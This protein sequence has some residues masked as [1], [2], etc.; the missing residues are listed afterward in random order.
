[1]ADLF[2]ALMA[3][4]LVVGCRGGQPREAQPPAAAVRLTLL[5]E[6]VRAEPRADVMRLRVRAPAGHGYEPGRLVAL[7]ARVDALGEPV[8]V[9]VA[10]IVEVFAH[11]FELLAL[12][13]DPARRGQVLEVGPIPSGHHF[14]FRLGQILA[15]DRDPRRAR[16]NMGD[17][18]GATVGAM[19]TVL[20]DPYADIDVGGRSL[21]RASVGVVQVVE[22]DPGGHTALVELRQGS[23]PVGAYVRH[24][25]HEPVA[26]RPQIRILVARFHGDRGDVYRE[27][28]IQ[29][30]ERAVRGSPRSEVSVDRSEQS[31]DP[32]DA[33][34]AEATRLGRDHRADL[35]VWGSASALGDDLIVRPRLTL[36][37]VR[38]EGPRLWDPLVVAAARLARAEPDALSRRLHGLAAYLV[39]RAY[40]TD[41]EAK[42]EGSYARAASHF[43][44]AIELGDAVEGERAELALFE[45]LDRIG[46]WAGA[47]RLA[48]AI[49][50]SGR[51]RG[52]AARRAA[53]LLLRARV[54]SRTGELGAALADARAAAEAFDVLGAARER[55]LALRHVADILLVKGQV[56]ASLRLLREELLPV[57]ERLGD[58]RERAVTLGKIADILHLRGELDEAL[59]IRREEVL[60]V[61]TAVGDPR[62]R[63]LTQRDIS[64]ALFIR[65]ELDEALR[66]RQREVLPVLER[67]GDRREQA[68]TLGRIADVLQ[69]RGDL[70]AAL[71]VWRDQALPVLTALG[72][73]AGQAHT[74]SRMA[75]VHQARGE[76][77][78]A[79][80][81]RRD[82]VLPRY[83]KLGDPRG[84]AITLGKLAL[85]T[86]HRG[87]LDEALRVL[88]QEQLPVHE[89]LGDVLQRAHTLSE[90]AYTR[91]L[92]GEVDVA[93]R[94]YREEVLPAYDRLGA[95][96]FRAG[97]TSRIASILRDHGEADEALRLYLEEVLPVYERLG[98]QRH[99]AAALRQVAEVRRARGERGEALRLLRDAVE[100]ARDDPPGR[101]HLIAQMV[102]IRRE[103]GELDEALRLLRDELLPLRRAIGNKWMHALTLDELA[104]LVA[105]RGELDEAIRV[106]TRELL[107]M[108][109]AMD[110][111][112]TLARCRWRTA[113]VLL[114]RG[115]TGDREAAAALLVQAQAT[116]DA[117]ALPFARDIAAMRAQHRL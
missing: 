81:I 47:D 14:G 30:L 104:E 102:E 22:A 83:D 12:W 107:P 82:E 69:V 101:A 70:E 38:E 72:D 46:D 36:L 48:R 2:R 32:L 16:I 17:A 64:D 60:P 6:P 52:L 116:A 45:C 55:A 25:G 56:D 98:L 61:F 111:P 39:G 117:H 9:G 74:L 27:A 113:A 21:G 41:F 115:A 109:Q 10:E 87:E 67:L 76:R 79:M 84:R 5:A 54:A 77:V 106:R 42:V 33:D 90:I 88:E 80:R 58:A 43:R 75:D 103:G 68:V 28:L 112:D 114:A 65:G 20:G 34:D 105:A 7:L 78:A 1:M 66:L 63:A 24:A 100:R 86:R 96:I 95:V 29:A 73:L 93:L 94:L 35:V 37:G 8:P 57:F 108:L 15:G 3:V 31:V 4:G 91:Q 97:V 85:A 40:F 11:S 13:V 99:R 110:A 89:A 44:V 50:A 23:A 19:Y 18:H 51:T 49:E 59:R 71:R 62:Q 92:R 53:G 26:S